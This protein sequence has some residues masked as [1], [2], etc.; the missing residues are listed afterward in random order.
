MDHTQTTSAA[1]QIP[2]LVSCRLCGKSFTF[3]G[4]NI[5]IAH[6]HTSS[7]DSTINEDLDVSI[8]NIITTATK[9]N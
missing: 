5:H 6:S 4:I 2:T 3:R 1:V 8:D 7:Q 9:K